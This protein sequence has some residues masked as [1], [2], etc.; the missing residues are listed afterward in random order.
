MLAEKKKQS[1]REEITQLRTEFKSLVERNMR[2]V[3]LFVFVFVFVLVFVLV[4]VVCLFG[5]LLN[6]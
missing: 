1:M 6:L 5:V 3:F 2:F 4:L